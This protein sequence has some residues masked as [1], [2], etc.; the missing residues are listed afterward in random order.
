MM[1]MQHRKASPRENL[2]LHA[3]RL[4]PGNSDLRTGR[5]TSLRPG[6]RLWQPQSRRQISRVVFG[7]GLGISEHAIFPNT[8]P[9]ESLYSV[10]DS[11]L[12]ISFDCV[13]SEP[14]WPDEDWP[15]DYQDRYD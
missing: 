11:C 13:Y 5:D 10:N 14:L 3:T 2:N 7:Y 1:R 8:C 12:N 4:I 6:R 9:R 15:C